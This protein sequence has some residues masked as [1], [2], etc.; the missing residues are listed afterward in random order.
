MRA[1]EPRAI[2]PDRGSGHIRVTGAP[3]FGWLGMSTDDGNHVVFGKRSMGVLDSWAEVES[4]VASMIAAR[5]SVA[6]VL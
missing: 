2:I 4:C 6:R 3:R 5:T 1:L